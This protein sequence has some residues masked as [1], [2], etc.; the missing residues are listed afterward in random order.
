MVDGIEHALTTWET[1]LPDEL[2]Y[3]YAMLR[4]HGIGIFLG[5]SPSE[6]APLLAYGAA[7]PT[8][9]T[10][11]WYGFP[12][13]SELR[14]PTLDVAGMPTKPFRLYTQLHD[15][16]KLASSFHN[17]FPRRAEWFAVGEDIDSDSNASQNHAATPDLNQLMSLF[18]DVGAS[19][20]CIEL[21]G[22]DGDDRGGWVVAD[23]HV[24][25]VDDVWATI[26]Q[27]M[28]SLVGS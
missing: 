3:F 28:A 11:C 4:Q 7:L 19:S 26:D 18:F 5:R 24:Q 1:V 15:G 22:S 12:P 8:G 9:E 25:P 14:H 27:W 6:H 23:G 20:L 21:G 10:V 17:G 16:F 13:T 2:P